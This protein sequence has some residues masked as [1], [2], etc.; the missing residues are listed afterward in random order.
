M[1]TGN[2]SRATRRVIYVLSLL[3]LLP[4]DASPFPRSP[5]GLLTAQPGAFL[6]PHQQNHRHW[7]HRQQQLGTQTFNEGLRRTSA[8]RRRAPRSQKGVVTMDT[9][10][11]GFLGVGPQ[12]VVVIC[13]VGYFLLG[14]TE[15][16]RLAK[17]IGKLVKQLRQTATEA[18]AAFS[19]TMEQQLALSEIQSAT[20]E[21]QDA[22][23]N[24]L[25]FE[26]RQNR[27]MA[28][29]AAAAGGE[30][31]AAEQERSEEDPRIT[32]SAAE[33]PWSWPGDVPEELEAPLD[34]ESVGFGSQAN[35]FEQQLSGE[36]N[37]AVLRGDGPWSQVDSDAMAAKAAAAAAAAA[38]GDGDY[39][40][41]QGSFTRARALAAGNEDLL[42]EIANLENDKAMALM[43]LDDEFEAKRKL[44]EETFSQ[45]EDVITEFTEKVARLEATMNDDENEAS[46]PTV[47]EAN[48]SP[49]YVDG[50]KKGVGKYSPTASKD[51]RSVAA[52]PASYLESLST[53][54]STGSTT[55]DV[56]AR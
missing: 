15:L 56:T 32:E 35:K 36:W 54:S 25:S 26:A 12:E 43:K 13:L 55:E 47:G 39:S 4:P 22:F 18:S 28:S 45:K 3:M 27:V 24:P 50:E 11:D 8:V 38:G 23:T 51:S 48:S 2:S 46:S 7:Q 31:E 20:Q 19:E 1:P 44:L 40:G 6:S 34:P 17:E 9:F 37:E 29:E 5:I 21:L 30:E 49:W 53:S 52:A 16:Y 10:S 33:D 41:T 14:P 42:I